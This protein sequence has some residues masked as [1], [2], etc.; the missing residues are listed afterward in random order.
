MTS[1]IS[2]SKH[3]IE[4]IKQRSYMAALSIVG[5]LVVLP[6]YTFMTLDYH[7]ESIIDDLSNWVT[8][9]F[10]G[11]FNGSYNLGLAVFIVIFGILAAVTGFNYLHSKIKQDF[12]ISLPVKKSQWFIINYFSGLLIFAVP[13]IIL[14]FTSLFIGKAYLG[15]I[16]TGS[17]IKE[18]ILAIFAGLAVYLIVYNVTVLAMTLTGSLVTAILAGAVIAVYGLLIVALYTGLASTFFDTWSYQSTFIYQN[19]LT[20]LTPVGLI[21]NILDTSFMHGTAVKTILSLVAVLGITFALSYVCCTH[22]AAEKAENALSYKKTAPFIKLFITV[23]AALGITFIVTT[24][25]YGSRSSSVWW[26]IISI[27][28]T[29]I[30][31]VIIEFIYSHD[32]KLVFKRKVITLFSMAAVIVILAVFKFDL[33]GYDRWVPKNENIE[34]A[35]II[36]SDINN[37]LGYYE[38]V[39]NKYNNDNSGHLASSSPENIK[40]IT[41]FAM[42]AVTNEVDSYDMNYSSAT[43]VYNLKNGKKAFRCYSVPNNLLVN[44]VDELTKDAEFNKNLRPLLSLNIDNITAIDIQDMNTKIHLVKPKDNKL[45]FETL[46][47]EYGSITFNEIN[48]SLPVGLVNLTYN[49][50]EDGVTDIQTAFIRVP[51][52]KSYTETFKVLN[53]LGINPAL[54]TDLSKIASIDYSH[55]DK[56]TDIFVTET[57]KDPERIKEIVDRAILYNE[58]V[59]FKYNGNINCNE[60]N[61]VIRWA[62]GDITQTDYFKS[63]L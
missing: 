1:K 31:S 16:L 46:V 36:N 9:S 40:T 59:L 3:I 32:I 25:F 62:N 2:Y 53:E 41:D 30:I 20:Y 37:Y 52:Y 18:S 54:E 14:A 22:Y 57:I 21:A 51:L 29:L 39:F 58:Y 34:S 4:N 49:Y 17:L 5:L 38:Y 12:F 15:S 45:L 24:M 50:V 63:D 35:Y 33:A 27:I 61:L 60:N 26:I 42:S 11:I 19:T 10:P 44:T 28:S 6:L 43:V 8:Y 56:E 47:K 7:K 13:F 48:N 23:P 55:T